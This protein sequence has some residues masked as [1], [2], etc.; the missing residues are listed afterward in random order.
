MGFTDCSDKDNSKAA[1]WAQSILVPGGVKEDQEHVDIINMV[2]AMV[3][4]NMNG[5]NSS[6]KTEAHN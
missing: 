5:T 1:Y 3:E 2:E 4:D 6:K